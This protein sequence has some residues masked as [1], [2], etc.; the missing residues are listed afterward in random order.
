MLPNTIISDHKRFL[1]PEI[2][3]LITQFFTIIFISRKMVLH[4]L[5]TWDSECEIYKIP[6]RNKINIPCTVYGF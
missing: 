1:N 4:A 3:L 6:V 5:Y 2:L